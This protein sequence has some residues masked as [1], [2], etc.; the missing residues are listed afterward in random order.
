MIQIH[1]DGSSDQDLRERCWFCRRMTPFWATNFDIAV[2][3]QCAGRAYPDDL[4]NKAQ[5]LRRERIAEPDFRVS[6][7]PPTETQRMKR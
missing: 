6:I 5:W 3:E 1:H 2:C 4:P 7:G